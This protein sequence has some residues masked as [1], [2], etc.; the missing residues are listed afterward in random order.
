MHPVSWLILELYD[1]I[2]EE[3]KKPPTSFTINEI[4]NL[5]TLKG[6]WPYPKNY[7][8]TQFPRNKNYKKK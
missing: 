1:E 6:M 3:Q 7:T 4:L 2:D 8:F 5:S